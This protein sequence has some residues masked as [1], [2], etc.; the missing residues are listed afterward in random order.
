MCEI[1]IGML[2]EHPDSSKI[3]VLCRIAGVDYPE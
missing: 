1:A 3:K 2:N